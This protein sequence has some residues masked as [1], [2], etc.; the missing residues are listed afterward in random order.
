MKKFLFIFINLYLLMILNCFGQSNYQRPSVTLTDRQIVT[1]RP[2]DKYFPIPY[3]PE[4][5][6]TILGIN[7]SEISPDWI[8]ACQYKAELFTSSQQL[9]YNQL[10][11]TRMQND[12]MW[13]TDFEFD[14]DRDGYMESMCYGAF[15]TKDK[16]IG[17]YL[18][19]IKKT[20]QKNVILLKKI[21]WEEPG[22]F[23]CFYKQNNDNTVYFGSGLINSEL[24][25]KITWENNKP[26]VINL[27]DD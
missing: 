3:F 4:T 26:V 20:N 25:W 17:N 27:Y 22:R 11:L 1:E 2:I 13:F 14:F 23:A 9:F 10:T 19:I 12:G 21:F 8:N 18:L 16:R 5:M 7:I 6:Q 24:Q 15:R